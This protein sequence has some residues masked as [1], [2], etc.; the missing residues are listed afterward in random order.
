MTGNL[1]E[2]TA[3]NIFIFFLKFINEH[4]ISLIYA[5][6]NNKYAEMAD[7]QYKL[8]NK[9]LKLKWKILLYI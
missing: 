9:N 4:N 7:T 1:D 8:T 5:T 2:I 3:D 6:H